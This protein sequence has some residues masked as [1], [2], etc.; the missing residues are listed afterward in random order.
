MVLARACVFQCLPTKSVDSISVKCSF[1][2]LYR[3]LISLDHSLT[4]E[5]QDR[6]KCQL[7]NASYSYI[8]SYD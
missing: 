7:K 8:Y 1:E 3:D 6:L 5:D 4:S 2:M